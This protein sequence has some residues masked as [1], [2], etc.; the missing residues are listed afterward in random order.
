MLKKQQPTTETAGIE[1]QQQQQQLLKLL[2]PQQQPKQQ[3]VSPSST[4]P[5]MTPVTSGHSPSTSQPASLERRVVLSELFKSQSSVDKDLTASRSV[6]PT[7]ISNNTHITTSASTMTAQIKSTTVSTTVLAVESSSKSPKPS[8]PTSVS[9][10]P[11]SVLKP[12]Q[13]QPL[14]APRHHQSKAI[15]IPVRAPTPPV[16]Y[17]ASPKPALAVVSE[18]SIETREALFAIMRGKAASPTRFNTP[19]SPPSISASVSFDQID[20]RETVTP[21]VTALA[22]PPII[23]SPPAISTDNSPLSLLNGERKVLTH[24]NS[25]DALLSLLSSMSNS[26]K[27]SS[28]EKAKGNQSMSPS[29]PLNSEVII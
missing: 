27:G 21:K 10:T 17:P 1:I 11:F 22:S 14:E 12:D 26:S 24:T 3:E 7:Q 23:I 18:K 29:Y 13:S 20:S 25:D 28:S 19:I 4:P 8:T 16:L 2:Q 6:N 15:P 9:S 5:I